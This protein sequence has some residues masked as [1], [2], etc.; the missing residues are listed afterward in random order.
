MSTGKKQKKQIQKERQNRQQWI[1]VIG[2][3]CALVLVIGILCGK[4]F[5]NKDDDKGESV[6]VTHENES[7]N[8]Q[9]YVTLGQYTGLTVSLAV[10]DEDLQDEID[11]IME[12]YV[13]Y[14]PLSGTA[15]AGDMVYASFEG[16]IDGQRVDSTCGEDYVELG[17]G[18]WLEGFEEGIIGTATG[19]TADFVIAVP[20]GAYG[21]ASIDGHNVEFRVTV[22]YICGEEIKPEYNDEFVQSISKKYDTVEAYNEHLRKKLKK[23]NEEQKAEYSWSDVLESCSVNGYPESLLEYS[24]GE[25]LQGYYDMAEVYGCEPEEIFT[26]FGYE[27]EQAFVEGDLVSLAQDTAKEYLVSEAIAAKEGISYT[28]EEYNAFRDEEYTYV[29]DT[30]DT[31]EAF[32]TDKREYLEKQTLLKSVKNWIAGQTN[33]TE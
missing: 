25:V 31:V 15:Q 4:V 5:M 16:Y 6:A 12:D 11:S 13:T 14:E 32:E 18:E 9:D 22:Q 26:S 29:T 17:S 21:D 8:P 33:F 20:E 24:K 3:I 19:D 28:Q 10:T 1:I 27:S 2:G 30:Y 23:E 7:Y